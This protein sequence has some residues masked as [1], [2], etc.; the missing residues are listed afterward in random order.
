[1][2]DFFSDKCGQLRIRRKKP[3]A[4]GNAIRLVVKLVGIELEPVGKLDLFQ[5]FGMKGG[6]SVYGEAAFDREP[7][8]VNF[9][10][11]DDG[12]AVLLFPVSGKF[13]A[14]LDEESA[15]DFFHDLIHARK[16]SL[17][18]IDGPLFKSFGENRVIRIRKSA[19]DDIPGGFPAKT[20]L[21]HQKAKKLGNRD[22][23]MRIV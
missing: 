9:T 22:D 20:V 4:L 3:A 14:K 18:N 1:M 15:V 16:E 12:H 8:H 7:G 5:K 17:K 2:P 6:D 11:G 10:V 23:R 13:F 19:R 21:V